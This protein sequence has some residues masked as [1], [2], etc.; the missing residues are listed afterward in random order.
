MAIIS[1]FAIF[2]QRYGETFIY[3]YWIYNDCMVWDFG[4]SKELKLVERGLQENIRSDE[5][6]LSDIAS[7]VIGSGGKRIRPTVT[8]LSYRVLG[9]KDTEKIV[10]ISAA[11]ELI[12]NATLIHDDIND[13][14]SRRRGRIAAH[15]KFGVH[16]ALVTGDFLFVKGFALGGKYDSRVVEITADAC[17]K[18]AEG[19]IRQKSNK[20]NI[21]MTQ[22]EYFEI[23][24]RKTAMP[25]Y[26]GAMVGAYLADGGLR[27]IRALG[28]FGL[29]IGMAFQIT[30]DILD[31][32][33]DGAR[34]G[35]ETGS[36]L[37]EGNVTILAISALA[38]AAEK[39][40]NK[41]SK[42][43][44]KRRKAS[45]DVEDALNLIRN[46]DAVEASMEIAKGF[47][48]RAKDELNVLKDGEYKTQ[49]L[50]LA[51]YV[52]QRNS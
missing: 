27:E 13:G 19:E 5:T 33:G 36:D 3:P 42:L 38:G 26:A 50:K 45:K 52:V 16:N 15:K 44:K 49:M 22:N 1:R 29:N 25:I 43:M 17:S 46:T 24:K 9:G 31:V 39:D 8:L 32:V 6:L 30:D 21:D 11:Y 2:V 20:W 7:Y 34:L 18:L 40:L 47:S 51:D 12:H 28:N 10:E 14:G 37:K 48:E 4:V 23:I 35:K 41:L